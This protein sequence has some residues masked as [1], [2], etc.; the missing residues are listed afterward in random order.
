MSTN[1]TTNY[2]LC[3]WEA[4]D[5]VL[6]TDFNQDNAKSDAALK[7][8]ADAI[9][10]EASARSSAVAEINNQIAL[11]TLYTYTVT[12]STQSGTLYVSIPSSLNWSAWRVIHIQ[13]KPVLDSGVAYSATFNHN[14]R[15][16]IV[17]GQT[18]NLRIQ[19]NPWEDET[20]AVT[21]L[22]WGNDPALFSFPGLSFR[23]ITQI[24]FQADSYSTNLFRSGTR[25]TFLGEH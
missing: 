15:Y 6:R 21:G 2:D 19:L 9:V 22:Q 11:R 10:A 12:S 20:Q 1:H 16:P 8:N 23:D 13:F 17:D 14:A 5:Q 25:V 4:T 3:Q 18:G 24:V 7:I